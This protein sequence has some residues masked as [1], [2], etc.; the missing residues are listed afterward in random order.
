M[1][2]TSIYLSMAA[3]ILTAVLAVPAAAQQQVPFNGTFHGNDTVSPGPSPTTALLSTTGTGTGTLLGQFSFT[4]ELTLNGANLTD[5]G[6]AHWV[7]ANGDSIDT[8][9]FGLAVPGPDVFTIAE[10]HIITGG[11]GRFAGAQGSFCVFRKHVVA[12][13]PD[14]T[15]VTFGSFEGTITSPRAAN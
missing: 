3:L 11:T 2:R 1:K 13:S 6:S 7:A 10:I 9:V 5:T 8:T 12:P 14:G 15:H 4:Q